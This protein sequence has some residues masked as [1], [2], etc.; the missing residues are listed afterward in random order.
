MKESDTL[1]GGCEASVEPATM[2]EPA[3]GRTANPTNERGRGPVKRTIRSVVFGGAALLMPVLVAAAPPAPTAI[4]EKR[5][6]TTWEAQWDAAWTRATTYY[7]IRPAST[8][9][10][11]PSCQGDLGLYGNVKDLVRA[12]AERRYGDATRLLSMVQDRSMCLD[13]EGARGLE[14]ALAG[15]VHRAVTQL[16]AGTQ[17]DAAVHGA[18]NAGTLI[19]DQLQ[20]T[21]RS[22][23]LPMMKFHADRLAP[24]VAR[25]PKAELGFYAYDW[26]RN[27]LSRGVDPMLMAGSMRDFGNYADGTCSMLEIAGAGY[28]CKGWV[29]KG[30]IGGGGAGGRGGADGG[31]PSIPAGNASV[32]CV[33][34]AAK[35]SGARGQLGCAAKAVAGMTFDPRT[36]SPQSLLQQGITGGAPGVRDPKCAL[37]QE[38]GNS[39]GNTDP[40]AAKKEPTTWDKIKDVASKA[41]GIAIDVVVSVFDK[42]PPVISEL[43]GAASAE[44][45]D[46]VR[47][48][49]QAAQEISAREALLKDDG[50]EEYYG[51]REGRVTTE[52]QA[53]QRT[54]P[55]RGPLGGGPGAGACGRGSNAARRARALFDCVTG[56]SPKPTTNRGPNNP[57]ISRTDPDQMQT[58]ATGA[59]ACLMNG[60][61]MPRSGFDDPKCSLARCVQGAA[62][63]PC[64]KPGGGGA[65]NLGNGA[66]APRISATTSPNCAEP[67]CGTVPSS[68]GGGGTIVGPSTNPNPT[69]TIKGPTGAPPAPRT[70]P[71]LGPSPVPTR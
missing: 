8:L 11:D 7:R 19:F 45:A 14:F 27:T 13:L 56:D 70:G 42:T 68:G 1:D 51:K 66:P 12:V 48:G 41:A 63:C 9:A 53:N 61:D 37:S 10:S 26:S 33:A 32:S 39:G 46:A 58:P 17:Q 29:G 55:D 47:G 62:S 52:P 30:G 2:R 23:W 36:T 24:I 71:G 22:H 59:M 69:P 21:R 6:A 38:A 49:L 34:S 15:F 40:E 25:Y 64:D 20:Y 4:A 54:G 16:P 3:V 44:G 60:G 43:K 57:L 28:K 5:A 65:K 67:P 31:L 18:L 35:S 50:V